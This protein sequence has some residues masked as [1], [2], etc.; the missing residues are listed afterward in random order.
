MSGL[1]AFSLYAPLRHTGTGMPNYHASEARWEV[2]TR[3]GAAHFAAANR[4]GKL[5]EKSLGADITTLATITD[6]E[7]REKL[8]S[9]FPRAE[10]A[11]AVFRAGSRSIGRAA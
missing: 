11:E 2:G 6:G 8:R 5:Y 10:D 3:L 1:S 4:R 9:F 7:L